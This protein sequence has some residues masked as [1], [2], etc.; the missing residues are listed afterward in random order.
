MEFVYG[1]VP[2]HPVI[3][4]ASLVVHE[5]C[6]SCGEDE[7]VYLVCADLGSNPIQYAVLDLFDMTMIEELTPHLKKWIEGGLLVMYGRYMGLRN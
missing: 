2:T 4:H 1:N 6:Q 5:A 3:P 7:A